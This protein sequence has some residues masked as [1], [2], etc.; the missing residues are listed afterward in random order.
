[1]RHAKS[2]WL[3][4]GLLA[5]T[6]A[7]RQKDDVSAA[8]KEAPPAQSQQQDAAPA[9]AKRPDLTADPVEA[10]QRNAA[11]RETSRPE[12]PEASLHEVPE[13]TIVRAQFERAI[14]TATAKPGE[15]VE[16]RLLDDLIAA[17]GA[18]VARSG[19]PVVGT[20]E[21]VVDSGKL[22]RRAEI[23]FRLTEVTANGGKAVPV[24]TSAYESTGESHGKR[25]AAYIAGGAAVGALLGQIIG[26]D[27][28][29]TLK[30]AAAG[31]AAGTGVAAATGD[32]DFEI[33]AG[34]TVAFALEKPL[35]LPSAG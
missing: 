2:T 18:V 17:D 22:G 27:T 20:V 9:A 26:K 14:S 24:S 1:M 6:P 33:E 21:H 19:S 10:S 34:R 12:R 11:R 8:V 15:K 25:N 4:T 35:E 3:L 30:G 29:S 23:R 28:S 5:L 13:G 16:G 7:C 32:L 31:A